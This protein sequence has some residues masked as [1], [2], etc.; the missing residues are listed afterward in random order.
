MEKIIEHVKSK[1]EDN[2]WFEDRL[3]KESVDE[4]IMKL[5]VRVIPPAICTSFY[6]ICLYTLFLSYIY[7]YNMFAILSLPCMYYIY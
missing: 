5:Q 7:I 4:F 3:Y 6:I 2:Y 1:F